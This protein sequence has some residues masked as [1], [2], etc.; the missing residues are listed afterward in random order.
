M[1]LTYEEYA[2][3]GGGAN[4]DAFTRLEAKARAQLDRM[5]YGR[6]TGENPV[7]QNVKYCMFD[8]IDALDAGESIAAMAG[9]REVSAMSNDGVSISFAA[10]GS[11]SARKSMARLAAIA[12]EWLANET[13][14]CGIP[15]LYAGV[16]MA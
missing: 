8:M 14:K 10:S 5:T 13:T 7:R 1:Y 11:G 16:V 6:I 9:G 15:L 4:V 12:H 2:G 3:M